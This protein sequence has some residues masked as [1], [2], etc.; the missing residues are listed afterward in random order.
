MASN[1]RTI[2]IL[3]EFKGKTGNIDQAI[4]KI[5]K[6]SSEINLGPKESSLNKQFTAIKSDLAAR[7]KDLL[8][9]INTA[10]SNEDLLNIDFTIKEIEKLEKKFNSFFNKNSLNKMIPKDTFDLNLDDSITQLKQYI[11]NIQ[12]AKKE[13][14]KLNTQIKTTQKNQNSSNKKYNANLTSKKNLETNIQ[15]MK[16]SKRDVKNFQLTETEENNIQNEIK[17][18]QNYNKELKEIQ[19]GYKTRNQLR[20]ELI[21]EYQKGKN[22]L[23][24][25]DKNGTYSAK[26]KID[27]ENELDA[28][29][30]KQFSNRRN[31]RIQEFADT[32]NIT[33]KTNKEII[34][35]DYM[36]VPTKESLTKQYFDQAVKNNRGLDTSISKAESILKN[37]NEEIENYETEQNNI[38]DKLQDL[39]NKKN[40]QETIL[41]D[42]KSKY[43]ELTGKNYI[44]KEADILIEDYE[45]T[46]QNAN[47][48]AKKDEVRNFINDISMILNQGTTKTKQGFKELSNAFQIN[49]RAQ[50]DLS[51]MADNLMDLFSIT[52]T[53]YMFKRAIGDAFQAVKDLDAV[54][55]ETAVVTDFSVSDMWDKIDEYTDQANKLGATIQGAYETRTLYYQQGLDDVEAAQLSEETIKM[56]RIAN[57]DYATTTDMMTAALRGFNMELNS[58]SAQRINDVYSELAAVSAS[59]TAEIAT[60]MTKTA[61][62]ANSAGA[63]FE[64]ISALLTQ[65]LETTREAPEN[66]GTALKT[67]IARFQE[68]KKSPNELVDIDGEMVDVNKIDT[69]LN[70]V[71]IDLINQMGTFK[72][73]DDVMLEISDKWDT[74]SQ[75]EQRYIATTA[76]GSRQ[77]SRFIAMVSDNERLK[78]LIESAKNS[79]GAADIQFGKTM[80][81]LEAKT[82]KFTNAYHEMVLSITDSNLVKFFVDF[83][84]IGISIFNDLI[85]VVELL[86]GAF[87]SV[88]ASL[89]TLSAL[90]IGSGIAQQGTNFLRNTIGKGLKGDIESLENTKTG[91]SFTRITGQSYKTNEAIPR[92]QDLTFTGAKSSKKFI[93]NLQ[94][95][96]RQ[97]LKSTGENYNIL[98][99]S[100]KTKK[101]TPNPEDFAFSYDDMVK[102]FNND[103][104][105]I[106]GRN[107]SFKN[108]GQTILDNIYDRVLLSFNESNSQKIQTKGEGNTF[109]SIFDNFKQQ[110]SKQLSETGVLPSSEEINRMLNNDTDGVAKQLKEQGYDATDF[111]NVTK[112]PMNAEEID[113]VA[114]KAD[115]AGAAMNKMGI[116]LQSIGD[117]AH[118][119][120]L[121]FIATRFYLLGDAVNGVSNIVTNFGPQL[122]KMWTALGAGG[123]VIA[124]IA[125]AAALIGAAF[126]YQQKKIDEAIE[127]AKEATEEYKASLEE[128]STNK[129]TLQDL[130]DEFTSLSEGVD[131]N[132]KNI[133][134][135]ADEFERYQ[136]IASQVAE[137]NPEAVIGYDSEGNAILDS[138]AIEESLDKLDGKK[139]EVLIEYVETNGE[140]LFINMEENMKN[141]TKDANLLD[142]DIF[143]KSLEEQEKYFSDLGRKNFVTEQ[144]KKIG[145]V[146]FSDQATYAGAGN[147]NG[148]GATSFT[149]KDYNESIV[150]YDKEAEVF[151]ARQ[152]ELNKMANL[153]DQ[154]M[155]AKGVYTGLTEEE[156]SALADSFSYLIDD[157]GSWAEAQLSA[158]A[159]INTLQQSQGIKLSETFEPVDGK[160]IKSLKDLQDYT[161]EIKDELSETGDVDKYNKSIQGVVEQYEKLAKEAQA[162][163]QDD[164][165]TYYGAQAVELTNYA[166]DSAKNLKDAYDTLADAYAGS[167]NI[168][169]RFSEYDEA[170]VDFYEGLQNTKE[171]LDEVLDGVDNVG[172]GSSSFWYAAE[173]ILGE[174]NLEDLD[175]DFDKV[176]SKLKSLSN[177]FAD[178]ESAGTYF[179]DELINKKDQ[180]NKAFGEEL[181]Q[182]D[183][184]TLDFEFE[185]FDTEQ[186]EKLADVLGVSYDTLINMM[187]AAGQFADIDWTNEELMEGLFAQS[188]NTFTT[189]KNGE[190]SSIYMTEDTFTGQLGI[191][192]KEGYEAK[193]DVINDPKSKIELLDWNDKD[194]FKGFLSEA[195]GTDGKMSTEEMTKV[196][197][198]MVKIGGNY[199]QATKVLQDS[200]LLG[201][202]TSDWETTFEIAESGEMGS[203]VSTIG[204]G[205]AHLATIAGLVAAIAEKEGVKVS[206]EEVES[207]GLLTTGQEMW[208]NPQSTDSSQY[209]N[210][211]AIIENKDL[212]E[213]E[214]VDQAIVGNRIADIQNSNMSA[215]SKMLTLYNSKAGASDDQRRYY[216]NTITKGF[217]DEEKKQYQTIQKLSQGTDS[218]TV[219]NYVNSMDNLEKEGS[220][221]SEQR[222]GIDYYIAS[223]ENPEQKQALMDYLTNSQ[224]DPKEKQA[225]MDYLINSQDTPTDKAAFVDYLL[226]KYP[227]GKDLSIKDAYADYKGNV[228]NKEEI[229]NISGTATFTAKVTGVAGAIQSAISSFLG[230]GA[231]GTSNRRKPTQSFKSFAKGGKIGPNGNGGPTLTGELGP[232]L[233]WIPSKSTSF[234]AGGLGPEMINL[235]SEAVVYPHDETKRIFNGKNSVNNYSGSAAGG[236]NY[237]GSYPYKKNNGSNSGSSGSSGSKSSG[238]SS[239][240]SS[241]S[242]SSKSSKS[243]NKWENPYPWIYNWEQKLNGVLQERNKIEE[244]YD[245]LLAKRSRTGSQIVSNL[246]EQMNILNQ[247]LKTSK[248]ALSAFISRAKSLDNGYGKYFKYNSSNNTITINRTNLNKVKDEK[249]GKKIEDKLSELEEM[250]DAIEEQ[251]SLQREITLTLEEIKQ[252]AREQEEDLYDKV[253]DVYVEKQQK[254]IDALQTVND[255]I[256]EANSELLDSLNSN[257]ERIR[258]DRENERTEEDIADMQARL[259]YLRLNTSSGNSVEIKQLEEEIKK[260]QEDYTDSLIDQSLS[261]LQEQ[262]DKASKQREKQIDILQKQLDEAQEGGKLWSTI[263]SIVKSGIDSKGNLIK[264]S[265]LEQLIKGGSD[266]VSGNK[267]TQNEILNELADMI[268]GYRLNNPISTSKKTSS[269]SS[270]NRKSSSSSSKKI[271]TSS[272]PKISSISRQL[273]YGSTGNDVK[274]LQ[275]ALKQLGYNPGSIDG[276]FGKNTKSAI[277]KFQKASGITANGI[278][279]KNTKAKFKAKG[280]KI[281]GLA[282]Y[283]GLAWLDGTIQKPEMVLNQEDTKN[284]IALKNLL[285]KAMSTNTKSIDTKSG[286]VN[287]DIY[288]NVEKISKDYDVDKLYKQLEQK[289]VSNSK[290][291]N[292]N[293]VRN[294][295]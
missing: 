248:S 46:T 221:T 3:M 141:I 51:M 84:T 234:I 58:T 83:G 247:Q 199:E 30:E 275:T 187:R 96:R 250:R 282:D 287:Y 251:R 260:A 36:T 202:D 293:K 121:D 209:Q 194:T 262:Q 133:G 86:P 15:N 213:K 245:I 75:M 219:S 283:T 176:N 104:I 197:D 215:M 132:G 119:A 227:T 1:Q 185:D 39:Q 224:M 107:Q 103:N 8:K 242:S 220:I 34:E 116:G 59:D 2:E 256:N 291:R 97:A 56:A 146:K 44:N 235:P 186:F 204:E 233:V 131:K 203:I 236:A 231:V 90:W 11:T 172:K 5:N 223:Q 48:K 180:I 155:S 200:G 93:K 114:T 144:T 179:F 240:K 253:L 265:T 252:D 129:S 18:V 148:I 54:M 189:K 137:I 101:N 161:Q 201:D 191:S 280:Y 183:G 20:Q 55:T 33:G 261:N 193:Q 163:G 112:K 229:S 117:I 228:T 218:K 295:K 136:E 284:F 126:M 151:K 210:N 266:Y 226:N 79:E 177:T 138:N 292:V 108:V 25:V 47:F 290:Y 67:I 289:I 211:K 286:D 88:A 258:Q 153:M 239:S 237:S 98:A 192:G 82:N 276:I 6:L 125:A 157:S 38:D 259:N 4:K 123:P 222:V 91:Q 41:N 246:K 31:K 214:V 217:T 64:N 109:K 277:Q 32:Y 271:S 268:A 106:T 28:R 87:G 111:S 7:Y 100:K 278:V 216:E 45:T 53:A 158:Q 40:T 92:N 113:K 170:N 17:K 149:Q 257:L 27:V 22:N 207:K 120:G 255:S 9:Y 135:T 76:A 134:L 57:M 171:V 65:G 52:S 143:S 160:S 152:E 263:Y 63:E 182:W 294:F 159:L 118:S 230:S 14:D 196:A 208:K 165:A 124:G 173:Q 205:N 174:K 102:A 77:Q 23:F 37:I 288:I 285:S 122:Q 178:T 198:Q 168:N 24:K 264:R 74:L 10:S 243:D 61:S 115:K 145:T 154:Y 147:A 156:Q 212:Y 150:N 167:Y 85:S 206:N 60:A 70:S 166:K 21:R 89:T 164:L 140:D 270:S 68:I 19:R 139:V 127:R 175:W 190:V 254:Q 72:D 16:D 29:Y 105:K 232:E 273:A 238:S 169:E 80:E 188:D 94:K 99:T 267:L 241:G 12:E 43:K 71:G 50:M 274:T 62:I 162:A 110:L 184:S 73:F 42:N 195:I 66:I 281:G 181:V 13:I 269:S 26:N 69:A 128:I 249:L 95:T 35:L 81:S 279:D 130:K 49:D 244:E 78:E 272:K 142:G 225:L